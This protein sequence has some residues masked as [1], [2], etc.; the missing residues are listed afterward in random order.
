ML[1]HFGLDPN[2]QRKMSDD[3]WVELAALAYFFEDRRALAV[4]RGVLMA[5][6]EAFRK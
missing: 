5:L 2:E 3:E 1:L 4:R 6:Q